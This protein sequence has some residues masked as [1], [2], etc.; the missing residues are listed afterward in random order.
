MGEQ[1][2]T[3]RRAEGPLNAE[4]LLRLMPPDWADIRTVHTL[5][6]GVSIGC[7]DGT[8]GTDW[9]ITGAAV[10][11]VGV[12]I[13]LDGRFELGFEGGA[14]LEVGPGMV[15]LHSTR[16]PATGWDE[17]KGRRAMRTVDIRFSSDA[18]RPLW[19]QA[20]S[21]APAGMLADDAS[22]PEQGSHLAVLPVWSP[23]ARIAG[24]I[25]NWSHDRSAIGALYLQ[26]KATEAL[27]LTLKHLNDGSRELPPPSDRRR[28]SEAYHRIQRHYAECGTVRQLA[29]S[30]GLGEKRLQ[31][32]FMSLYGQSVHACLLQARM[33]AAESLLKRGCTVTDTAYSVGFASLSHFIKAFKAYC[34]ATPGNWLRGGCS[35]PAR[36]PFSR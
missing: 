25:L 24:E 19:E 21:T 15:V 22:V 31:A 29:L 6:G 16:M 3:D 18:V 1:L 27:A 4:D 30:V 8:P 36:A 35:P 10:P 7:Y 23:I 17:F 28:L 14:P 12:A 32:G 33:D 26:G 13:I 11:S 5:A 9:A 34:G 2:R 20:L